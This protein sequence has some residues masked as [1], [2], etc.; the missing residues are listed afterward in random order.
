MHFEGKWMKSKISTLFK[1][2]Q[3]VDSEKFAREYVVF[4]LLGSFLEAF[5]LEPKLSTYQE[6]LNYSITL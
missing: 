3:F 4:E 6:K 1:M 5:A 2:D